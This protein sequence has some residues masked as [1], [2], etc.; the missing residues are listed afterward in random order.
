VTPEENQRA[1][2]RE[3][4]RRSEKRL[5]AQLAAALAHDQ[6]S[7][8]LAAVSVAAAGFMGA[9]APAVWP[10]V[11]AGAAMFFAAGALFAALS[12][13]PIA[14]YTA[15]SRAGDL[16]QHVDDNT[17]EVRVIAGLSANNDFYIVEN[18]RKT[19]VSA[20]AY[21]LAVIFFC[22]GLVLVISVLAANGQDGGAR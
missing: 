17:S 11:A 10:G 3:A 15:G 21:R 19:R 2:V 18:D 4:Y 22:L 14:L 1:L 8:V 12:A 20:F 6:R 5:D 16:K 13:L 9:L 7:Y